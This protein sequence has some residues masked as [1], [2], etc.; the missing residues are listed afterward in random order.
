MR[1]A[2]PESQQTAR[3]GFAH[4]VFGQKACPDLER[5]FVS[6]QG[7]DGLG[8]CGARRL[9]L[10]GQRVVVGLGAELAKRR[11]HE[12]A[13]GDRFVMATELAQALAAHRASDGEVAH[14]VAWHVRIAR[15]YADPRVNVAARTIPVQDWRALAPAFPDLKDELAALGRTRSPRDVVRDAG[16]L[17]EASLALVLATVQAVSDD[18]AM[19]VL[20]QDIRR[21]AKR[22]L[23]VDSDVSEMMSC[24]VRVQDLRNHASHRPKGRIAIAVEHS[25]ECRAKAWK[26]ARW[27]AGLAGAPVQERSSPVRRRVSEFT[28]RQRTGMAEWI[29]K[30]TP[31]KASQQVTKAL[32]CQSGFLARTKFYPPKDSRNAPA[33][34]ALAWKVEIG[35]IIH[36][37]YSSPPSFEIFGSFEVLDP[38]TAGTDF[39]EAFAGEAFAKITKSSALNKSLAAVYDQDPSPMH[40]SVGRFA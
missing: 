34:A 8:E 16:L 7:G 1:I 13:L 37:A 26:I 10:V 28:Q 19:H 21:A 17:V 33:R 27:A 22:G 12:P 35:D 39:A 20:I 6:S 30:A 11:D 9:V 5:L 25:D 24:A 4:V 2:E 14:A 31:T 23:L 32:V 15:M 40:S 3:F 18:A 38:K 29:Y 36:I